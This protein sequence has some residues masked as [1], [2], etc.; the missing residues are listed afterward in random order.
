MTGPD[1]LLARVQADANAALKAGA[2]DR[3]RVL[4]MVAS[5]IKK[6][7]IDAGKNE[8]SGDEALAVLRRAVKTSS[9]SV[10]QYDKAGRK[11]LADKER[12]EIAVIEAYLP[13][14]ATE[15]EI[16]GAVKAIVQ[17][18]GVSGMK[19]MGQVMKET[20]VRL[21]PSADGKTVSRVVAEVLK[22]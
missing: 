12:A 8:A 5:D 4:R 13:K 16:R 1:A 14:G 6:A 2:K 19:A 22:G 17:S 7:A 10:D 9:D 21:G 18:L 20:L 15:D 11:D 3:V